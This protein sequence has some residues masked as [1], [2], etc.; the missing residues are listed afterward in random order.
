VS[1]SNREK[2]EY[3]VDTTQFFDG[4][5]RDR[6]QL[7]KIILEVPEA[8]L[9]QKGVVGEWSIKNV[10]AHLTAWETVVAETLP[11]RF[12]TGRRPEILLHI[13]ADED[14]WNAEEVKAREVFSPREQIA[15]MEQIRHQFLQELHDLGEAGLQRKQPWPQCGKDETVMDYVLEQVGGHEREHLEAIMTGI[16]RLSKP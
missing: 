5:N 13:A 11:E 2:E 1:D 9:D 15:E 10:L 12:A 6:A 14:G 3:M 4:M 7:V 8:T 16:A